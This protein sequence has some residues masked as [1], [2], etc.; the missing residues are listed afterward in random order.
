MVK[1]TLKQWGNSIGVRIPKE[2][3]YNSN[4]HINDELE[5]TAFNGGFYL[6]KKARKSLRDIAKP[7]INT[8][9]WRFDRDEANE[10]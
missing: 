3:L 9:D 1:T 6:Q 8:K 5:I 2:A 7:I 10:R 4:L